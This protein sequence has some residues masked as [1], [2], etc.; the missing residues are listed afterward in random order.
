MI[1]AKRFVVVFFLGESRSCEK[2]KKK[3]NNAPRRLVDKLLRVWKLI[4]F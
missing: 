4:F 2:K 3:K 1:A